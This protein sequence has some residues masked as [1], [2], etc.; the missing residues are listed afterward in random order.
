MPGDPDPAAQPL[1]PSGGSPRRALTRSEQMARIRGAD[2][3]P[4]VLLR[5]ILAELAPEARFQP[6]LGRV[7]PDLA[8]DDEC[9]V[10]FVDGCFWHGCPEHYTRPRT[11]TAYWSSHLAANIE[12]DIRQ[13]R[14]LRARGW[15]VHRLWEHE[16]ATDPLAAVRELLRLRDSAE[17]PAERWVACAVVPAEEGEPLECWQ[18]VDLY[19]PSRTRELVRPRTTTGPRVPSRPQRG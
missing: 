5:D 19:D 6:R 17:Q 3:R 7:R 12:R 13:T 4:E 8:F 15:R 10:V 9:L 1:P 18:L 2:T 14:E 16:L 11:R